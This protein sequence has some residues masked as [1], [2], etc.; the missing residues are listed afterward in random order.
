MHVVIRR[1]QPQH[2]SIIPNGPARHTGLQTDSSSV[3]KNCRGGR[4]GRLPWGSLHCLLNTRRALHRKTEAAW[5]SGGKRKAV[6]NSHVWSSFLGCFLV[7]LASLVGRGR[8]PML[9]KAMGGCWPSHLT[10]R[11]QGHATQP[12]TL[13]CKSPP[14]QIAACV[15]FLC[16]SAHTCTAGLQWQRSWCVC[17]SRVR[18]C[19]QS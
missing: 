16:L 17:H 2:A 8:V 4:W 7:M 1:P 13:A 15:P 12:N 10:G 9:C 6:L 3:L 18:T 11:G 14:Q 19:T 5:K